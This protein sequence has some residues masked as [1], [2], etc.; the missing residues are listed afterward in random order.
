MKDI[1]IESV[2]FSFGDV[3]R[4]GSRPEWGAGHVTKVEPSSYEGKPVCRL[5]VRFESAGMKTLS[6][7][8]APIQ[9]DSSDEG[10]SNDCDNENTLQSIDKMAS[11]FGVDIEVK[12]KEFMSKLP[13]SCR[14]PFKT[15]VEKFKETAQ[16]YRFDESPHG[17]LDWSRAQTSLEDPMTRFNRMELES[18][19]ETWKKVRDSYFKK[20]S[21]E[22]VDSE[23]FKNVIEA[24]PVFAKK[25]LRS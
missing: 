24:A 21:L 7:P 3:V 11:Q 15:S 20:L 5:T 13:E 17:L 19:Y 9:L 18:F 12:I 10:D 23:D 8:P 16:L 25:T 22:L 4:H 1:S 14:D 6:V 2:S